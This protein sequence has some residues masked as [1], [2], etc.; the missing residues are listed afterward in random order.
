MINEEQERKEAAAAV[1][2]LENEFEKRWLLYGHVNVRSTTDLS[3][4]ER[5]GTMERLDGVIPYL[6]FNCVAPEMNGF[7]WEHSPSIRVSPM[8]CFKH[9]FDYYE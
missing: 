8:F 1:E 9:D 3:S 7:R 2:W 5:F 4:R 6:H